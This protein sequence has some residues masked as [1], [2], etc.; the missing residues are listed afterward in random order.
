MIKP[1][2]IRDPLHNL[3]EFGSDQFEHTLWRVIQTPPFQR[4]RR[5]RQ[6]GFSEMV[7]PG[8]THTRFAHCIGTFHI[9]RQ[10]MRIINRYIACDCTRQFRQHQAEVALAAA[11]VHDAGHGMFSHAFEEIG[12]KENLPMARH[13]AVS[14]ALIRDSEI[15]EAF[16]ELG[17][18]FASDVADVIKG[19][20]PGNLYDAVVS[21]QFDADRLDYMQRDRMMTGVQS[22]GIDATWLMANLEIASVP[23]GTDK[24][25]SGAIET[26]VLGPKAFHAAENY[27]LS[28]FQLY[29]NVY[30]H[31][32]TRGAEKTFSAL[33]LRI[34]EL[35]RDGKESATGLPGNHPIPRFAKDPGSLANAL[36]LDDT[37]FWGALPMMVEADDPRIAEGA[38]RLWKRHLPKCIDIRRRVEQ[39]FPLRSGMPRD[40]KADRNANV[41]LACKE[42]VDQIEAFSRKRPI[43]SP[44]VLVDQVR[45]PAYKTFGEGRTLLNQILIRNGERNV[46]DMAH[47]SPVVESAETFDACR[48]YVV[49]DDT[50]ARTEI[51]NI[52]RTTG[53]GATDVQL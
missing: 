40:D 52:I 41:H 28:L 45:R 42:I 20:Q 43:S 50:D 21:S 13:E 6:L 46:T 8:A 18:G 14:E 9:A 11:L 23:T 2:R 7:F 32:T 3:I 1:Q 44:Q 15:S 36:A 4:L 30:L 51:E 25:E 47:L 29:P 5:I 22:S 27:V 31:K 17:S 39:R 10:L 37:V 26:L 19:G 49:A 33:V 24:E 12:K 38:S 34:L 53:Q 35:V 16:R 48:V